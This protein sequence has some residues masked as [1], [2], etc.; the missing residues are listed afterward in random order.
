MIPYGRQDISEDDIA[1]VVAVLRSDYL[2]QGP[3]V[4][5][6]R[7][8]RSRGCGAAHA[9]AV[10]SA[11][12]ALH[13]ACMALGLGPGDDAV[14]GARHLCRLRQCALY[15]GATVDFVDIDPQTWTMCPRRRWKRSWIRQR[16]TG[17]LPKV[18]VP[19]HLCGQSCDM[20]EI[21]RAGRA[22]TA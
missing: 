9:V 17:R 15:C 14:D 4:P 6:L 11:T 18:I 1:A 5:R 2:T 22:P 8:P 10:N 13:I 19:V 3:A 21:G 16:P 20:A 7:R 12:S